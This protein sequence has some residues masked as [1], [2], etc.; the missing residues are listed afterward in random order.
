MYVCEGHSLMGD[1]AMELNT[2]CIR[3]RA[4]AFYIICRQH[5]VTQQ[6]RLIV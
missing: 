2:T 5:V 6:W 4:I 1:Y 3:D